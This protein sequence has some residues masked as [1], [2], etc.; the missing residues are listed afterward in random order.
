MGDISRV[1]GA[2]GTEV[3]DAPL[4]EPR[5]NWRHSSS[6]TSLNIIMFMFCPSR[7]SNRKSPTCKFTY[8]GTMH[9]FSSRNV[10]WIAIIFQ[11]GYYRETS[12]RKS[13]AWLFVSLRFNSLWRLTRYLRYR[14]TGPIERCFENKRCYP[15]RLI[16]V[17]PNRKRI[18]FRDCDTLLV[19][20]NQWTWFT[21]VSLISA[22]TLSDVPNLNRFLRMVSRVLGSKTTAMLYSRATPDNTARIMNQNQR[23]M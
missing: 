20:L 23:K 16:R 18:S 3:G 9:T 1:L 10:S 5:F 14:E 2:D 19:D 22:L 21:C 17:M 4:V 15:D 12:P 7:W 6:S 11:T 13:I 8:V